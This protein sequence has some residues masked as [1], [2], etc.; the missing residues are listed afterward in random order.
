VLGLR[1]GRRTRHWV[2]PTRTAR[3]CAMH[4]NPNRLETSPGVSKARFSPVEPSWTV[5]HHPPRTLQAATPTK[6]AHRSS[7]LGLRSS[8]TLGESGAAVAAGIFAKTSTAASAALGSPLPGGTPQTSG[9]TPPVRRDSPEGL[10]D[11][12]AGAEDGPGALLAAVKAGPPVVGPLPG[13]RGVWSGLCGVGCVEW[14]VGSGEWG[15][16]SRRSASGH[17]AA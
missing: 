2:A 3:R 5:T 14:A 13:R 15:V 7:L 17:G 4:S 9:P 11:L 16:G 8:A 6:R 10:L 1:C 12:P